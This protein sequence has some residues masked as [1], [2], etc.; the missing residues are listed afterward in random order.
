MHSVTAAL[1]ATC[2]SSYGHGY[3]ITQSVLS[4]IL[5]IVGT[6]SMETVSNACYLSTLECSLTTDVYTEIAV[7]LME[8]LHAHEHM[9][10]A[11]AF[12]FLILLQVVCCTLSLQLTFYG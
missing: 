5:K 2:V 7:D 4:V 6:C 8:L 9:T 3:N 12:N 11:Y 1:R 10:T